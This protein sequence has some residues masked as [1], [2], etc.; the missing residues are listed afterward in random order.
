[1]DKVSKPFDMASVPSSAPSI[2]IPRVFTNI[3]WK[4]VKDVF[5][6]LNLGKVERVDMV[7]KKNEKGESFK[8]VF[9]HFHSWNEDKASV[10]QRLLRGD[11]VKI[12]Y[13]SPKP[14]YWKCSASRIPRPSHKYKEAV[15]NAAIVEEHRGVA[16]DPSSKRDVE[17]E[18]LRTEVARLTS[19]LSPKTPSKMVNPPNGPKHK[20]VSNEAFSDF[21][22]E[23]EKQDSDVEKDS[24]VDNVEEGRK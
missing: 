22:Q 11:A 24:D 21:S 3:D 8:R 18:R 7:L 20:V 17:L 16:F 23:K 14:W 12:V 4:F 5:E 19:Q 1:M 15:P 9:V 6:E 2:C 10:R 13:D